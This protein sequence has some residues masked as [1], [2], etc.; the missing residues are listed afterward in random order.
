MASDAIALIVGMVFVVVLFLM[1]LHSF[2]SKLHLDKISVQVSASEFPIDATSALVPMYIV[3]SH[4]K[5]DSQPL[6]IIGVPALLL[7]VLFQIRGFKSI[8]RRALDASSTNDTL[9]IPA[10]MASSYLLLLV[11]V[12]FTYNITQG[13]WG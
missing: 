6:L 12:F 1:K 2:N 11:A 4:T 13:V 3:L 5:Y 8:E 9:V 10:Y 7:A